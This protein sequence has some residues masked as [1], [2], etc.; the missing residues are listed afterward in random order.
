MTTY[1]ITLNFEHDEEET[2]IEAKD[3]GEALRKALSTSITHR[4]D[5]P[6]SFVIVGTLNL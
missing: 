1:T 2:E 4:D 5:F 3:A 6:S